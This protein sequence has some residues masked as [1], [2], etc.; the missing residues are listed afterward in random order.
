MARLA[1][2]VAPYRICLC[3]LLLL[4]VCELA[5]QGQAKKP[6]EPSGPVIAVGDVHGDFGDFVII[7]QRTGLIDVQHHWTSGGATLVQVGDLLDRGPKPREVMDLMMSLEKEAVQAGGQVVGLIGNHEMMNIMGDL[8]YVTPRDFAS[9]TDSNSAAR[10]A[11]AFQEYK[12]W[13]RNHSALMTELPQ[14]RESTEAEWKARHPQ[15]YVEQR[16]AF[17]PNGSYGKW[18]REHSAVAK[19]NGVI[20]LH[21]GIRPNLAKMKLDLINSRIADDIKAFDKAKQCRV[22]S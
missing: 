16:E 22:K 8:R 3:I 17:S 9:Y 15:G 14:P 18:L 20:F 21:G 2:R 7:L 11:A 5:L 12:K 10:Q 4:L 1:L 6:A 19:L 13:R